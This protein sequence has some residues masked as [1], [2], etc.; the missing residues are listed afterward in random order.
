M[1]ADFKEHRYYLSDSATDSETSIDFYDAVRLD[2]LT[3]I[4]MHPSYLVQHFV[5]RQD[6]LYYR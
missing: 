2:G 1:I 3:R 6:R 5:N 4:E